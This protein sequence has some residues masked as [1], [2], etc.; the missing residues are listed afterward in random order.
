[1]Y[2]I[3]VEG[4]NGEQETKL[5]VPIRVDGVDTTVN[6]VNNDAPDRGVDNISIRAEKKPDNGHQSDP[7]IMAPISR[8]NTVRFRSAANPSLRLHLSAENAT[9]TPDVL[10]SP[11]QQVTVTGTGTETSEAN[12]VVKIGG[13]ET[14]CSIKVKAMKKRT[15][16]VTIHAVGLNVVPPEVPVIPALGEIKTYL[17]S[18]FLPQLNADITV[19]PGSNEVPLAWDMGRASVFQLTG[20]GSEGLHEGNGT[21]D[22]TNSDG[23]EQEDRYI[24]SVLHDGNANINIYVLT[25]MALT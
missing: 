22:F 9:F 7:W 18:V 2:L 21:F 11:D 19:T 10:N 25:R 23:L 14:I 1:M 15:V 13:K 3:H 17:D 12:L 20:P 8:T 5:A 6:P 4:P 16:K 24:D